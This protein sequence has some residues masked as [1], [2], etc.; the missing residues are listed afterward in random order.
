MSIFR[1]LL[2]VPAITVLLLGGCGTY[3]PE[4]QEFPG[5]AVAGQKLVHAIIASIHCE[6]RNA[7]SDVINQDINMANLN[8][9]VR[10]A[11]WIDKWGV[12]MQLTLTIDEKGSLS[13]S[14]VWTPPNPMTALFTLG[15]GISASSDATRIDVY[16][17]NYTVKDLYA[18]GPCGSVDNADVPLGS[19]LI[20]GDL[21]TKEWLWSQVDVVRSGDGVITNK[22]SA[23]THEVKFEVDTSGTL[24]P[25][26]TFVHV[27][28]N[29]GGPLLFASRNRTHDLLL[30]FGPVDPGTKQLV[31][32][33]ANVFLAAQIG[34][35][36]N[37]NNIRNRVGF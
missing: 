14:A 21:K 9:G 2:C 26:W 16:N 29:Q 6:I 35:A 12:A 3:V 28:V 27:T 4:I 20:Q 11:A 33:A 7:I 37:S 30:T 10:N 15:G 34:N 5:D 23:L 36:I 19:L 31:S 18:Q 22:S 17:Y 8:H 13:P 32:S 24:N 1:S 25:A